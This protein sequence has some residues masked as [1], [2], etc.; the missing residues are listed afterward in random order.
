MRSSTAGAPAL[1]STRIAELRTA[2]RRI[3]ER[4]LFGDS[5]GSRD[6]ELAAALEIAVAYINRPLGRRLDWDLPGFAYRRAKRARARA[7]AIVFDE[8]TR[9]RTLDDPGDDV[10]G[11]LISE[12]DE[13]SGLTDQE[14]RDQVVS[15]VAAGY[16]TTASA[17]G[18]ACVELATDPRHRK[19]IRAEL[20]AAGVGAGRAP[21]LEQLRMLTYTSAFLQEVLRVHPPAIWSGRTAVDDFEVHGHR[22]GGGS[23]VAYSP[24]VTHH[25]PADFRDPDEFRPERWIDGDPAADHPRPSAYVP[26]GGG[27]RRCLGFAFALQELTVMTALVAQRV[28]LTLAVDERPRHAGTMSN[29]PVGGVPVRATPA[30]AAPSTARGQTSSVTPT[31]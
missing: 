3:A 31:A 16:D 4:C 2:I 27:K 9:R 6:A 10:L 1:S 29:A 26:F 19:A 21:N 28:N 22:V 7:D 24:H 15:L 14:V 13:G 18:W 11:W 25:D 20:T 23:R 12:Q 8:I 17:I 5:L 30:P